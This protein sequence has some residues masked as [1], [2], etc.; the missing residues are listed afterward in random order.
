[1]EGWLYGLFTL[2]GVLAGGLFTYLGMKKQLK[3]QQEMDLR[4]WKREVWGE[5]LLE[6]REE[7][8]IMGSKLNTLVSSTE[9]RPKSGDVDYE[10]ANQEYNMA[11]EN[12]KSYIK[13]EELPKALCLQFD[14]DIFKKVIA[15]PREYIL[16]GSFNILRF[17]KD[18]PESLKNI[19][20]VNE[21]IIKTQSL[22]NQH[23]E[24]L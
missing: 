21:L 17:D 4:Q 16:S 9:R 7:L 8:A 15:I 10:A 11:M 23:L 1:M 13:S 20:V 24:S 19:E 22:I 5:P 6:L 18:D 2:L 3:Q 12:W 14:V